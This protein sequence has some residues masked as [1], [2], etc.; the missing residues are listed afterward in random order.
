MTT[1]QATELEAM[2]DELGL[3][4]ARKAEL[5]KR[6]DELKKALRESGEVKVEGN[7]FRASVSR[8]ETTKV[9]YKG[10]CEKLEPSYQ[11]VTA[12]TSKGEQCNVRVV[13]RNGK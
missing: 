10:I 11:L 1:A 7:L 2:V 9:D 6:E 13:A 8:F 4:L 3:L 12:Y 5:S